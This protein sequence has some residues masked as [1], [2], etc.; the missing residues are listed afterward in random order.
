MGR[1][2]L[3]LTAVGL[4]VLAGALS[5]GLL[6]GGHDALRAKAGVAPSLALPSGSS[7]SPSASS[8]RSTQAEPTITQETLARPASM[9]RDVRDLP[10]VPVNP[11]PVTP[12]LE[13]P[14]QGDKQATQPPP[15]TP[16]PATPGLNAPSGLINFA[17]LSHDDAVT[18]GL[19]GAGWP[20][21]TNGDV[22]PNYYIQ[23]VNTAAG[24]YSKGGTKLAAFTLN[25]LWSGA[26]TGTP[27]DT[28]HNG[29]PV[30][31]YDPM[32][33]RWFIS[34]FA[35]TNIQDGPY[36]ECVAVSKTSN[37]VAG[38]WWLYAI[39]ASDAT[40]PWL[41]DYP[42]MGIWPDGLYI[43]YNMF[44]CT[45]ANCSASTFQEVRVQ[46][47]QRTV[48]EAGGAPGLINADLN[49]TSYFALTPSNMRS[50][51]GSPPAGRENLLVSESGTLFAWEVWKFHAVF[52]GPGSTFTGPT[53]VSQTSY[54]VAP[55]SVP[56]PAN[57][58]D[59]L[60]ERV[61]VQNQYT[62]IGAA[63]SLWVNH[64][65]RTGISPAPAGIQWAQ[66]NVT[67]GSIS[68]SP[69]QQQ[70]YGNLAADGL[71]RWMGSLAVDKSGNMAIG[72]S[73]A[74]AANNPSI[75]FNGRLSTDAAGSLGGEAT[76]I[77]GGGSQGAGSCSAGT[78]I[79]WGDY[80]GMSL[81]PDG[82]TFWFTTEYY[83]AT[84]GN[85]NTRIGSMTFAPNS[86][87]AIPTA[88]SVDRFAATRTK[89]GVAVTWRT[90]SEAQIVGFDVLRQNAAGRWTKLNRALIAA[91]HSG[92]IGGASYRFLDRAAL[93]KTPYNYRLRVVTTSG[94][95]AAYGLAAVA[96]A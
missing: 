72:Y 92:S 21:D 69:V 52:G 39:P 23:T 25:S 82:C 57:S 63:E 17:G 1:R 26:G 30:A 36:Y 91:R 83:A 18:G 4:V 15:S 47:L 29:D 90:R 81:D 60:R 65:V 35:W 85:W 12:D 95:A 50:V 19:A 3:W 89:H 41:N 61:M 96:G 32:A 49:S 28:T 16:Q 40:H 11:L 44:D 37:P 9:D 51:T 86:C 77:T 33:D 53:T 68:A 13:P 56:T 70:I 84:G 48:M 34:D 88:V 24:I 2:N 87:Q 8:V 38:G 64:T 62:N 71:N 7:S 66:I 42:K 27:C 93:R 5:A 55:S 20:P 76:M 80:S 58:L 67:G 54:T 43:T 6:R 73:A 10:A 59:T 46:A 74:N 94:K 79:R 45:N 75:R 14:V 78:C 31:L 22:G